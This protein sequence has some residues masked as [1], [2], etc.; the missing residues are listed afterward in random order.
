MGR[1]DDQVKLRGFRIEPAEV[2]SVLERHSAVAECAVA[3]FEPLPGDGQLVAYVVGDSAPGGDC[4]D[5]LRSHCRRYL[6][7][8]M[9]PQSFVMLPLL[10]RLTNGKVDRHG[11][12]APDRAS[13][14]ALVP[15]RTELEAQLTRLWGELLN[16]ETVGIRDDFFDLGGHSLL[17]TRLISRLRDRLDLEIP[18][19]ILFEHSTVAGLADAIE[20]GSGWRTSQAAPGPARRARVETSAQPG[21][22]AAPPAAG[23]SRP[24]RKTIGEGLE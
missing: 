12:P 21:E 16:V 9:V 4:P 2:E 24:V 11:L 23:Y 14:P 15:P 8:W 10:P 1:R 3:V 19:V 6:P 22:S 18:L 13:G 17:A 7:D 5:L 20:S